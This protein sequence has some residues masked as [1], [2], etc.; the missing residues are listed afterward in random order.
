MNEFFQNFSSYWKEAQ[1]GT[2]LF[3]ALPLGSLFIIWLLTVVS[4]KFITKRKKLKTVFII[5]RVWIVSSLAVAAIL[6]GIICYLWVIN[7]FSDHPIQLSLLLSLFLAMLVPIICFARLRNYYTPEGIKEI[8]DQ[9]KTQRQ[10]DAVI[11]FTKKAFRKNK[12][13][14]IIPFI[15]FL[16]LLFILNKGVNL[17]SIVIDN[18]PSQGLSFYEAKT[19]LDQTV[20]ELDDNNKIIIT[21][22][23]QARSGKTSLEEIMS[24]K[25]YKP[26]CDISTLI[27]T[28]L[29]AMNYISSLSLMAGDSP[30]LETIWQNYL[31][32]KQATLN[33]TFKNKVLMIITDGLENAATFSSGKFLCS[34]KEYNAFYSSENTYVIDYAEP[35]NNPFME[36]AQKCGFE[37]QDGRTKEDFSFALDQIL[38][39]FKNNWFLIFWTIVIVVIMTIIGI[40]IQPKKIA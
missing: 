3:W 11:T 22:M 14:F 24:T 9:P 13:F 2:F 23:S 16:M 30:I 10:L 17:I 6:I 18:T 35:Q 40:I 15:G 12:I 21:S 7:I 4:L 38:T 1:Y 36:C 31:F 27:D 8:T 32:T 28:K 5:N 39:T 33:N 20:S 26:T 37:I 19:A 34:S 25:I 29:E